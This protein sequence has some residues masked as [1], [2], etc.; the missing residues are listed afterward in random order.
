LQLRPDVLDQRADVRHAGGT[1][2]HPQL[3][4][5]FDIELTLAKRRNAWM[6]RA[7]KQRWRVNEALLTDGAFRPK[8]Y[9]LRLERGTFLTQYDARPPGEQPHARRFA[10]RLTFDPSPYPPRHESRESNAPNRMKM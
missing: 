4:S 9:A 7:D 6:R 5:L 1:R 2:A 10:L 8:T 3:L